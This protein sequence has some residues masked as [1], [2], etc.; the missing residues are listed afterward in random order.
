M[1]NKGDFDIIMTMLLKVHAGSDK[2]RTM[3]RLSMSPGWLTARHSRL[4]LSSLK[5][6]DS[7]LQTP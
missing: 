6:N 3:K 7:S 1:L 5:N 4:I 2:N